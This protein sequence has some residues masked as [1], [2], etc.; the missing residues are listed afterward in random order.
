MHFKPLLL[1]NYNIYIAIILLCLYNYKLFYLCLLIENLSTHNYP[2]LPRNKAQRTKE[3]WSIPSWEVERRKMRG[4]VSSS[5]S[6][7]FHGVLCLWWICHYFNFFAVRIFEQTEERQRLKGYHWLTRTIQET[8]GPLGHSRT[9]SK[10]I[11][12]GGFHFLFFDF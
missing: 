10:R 4:W 7:S 9:I 12:K 3:S 2:F 6:K 8:L 1:L 11:S 5:P